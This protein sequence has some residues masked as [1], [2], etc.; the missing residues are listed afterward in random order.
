MA[1]LD[2]AVREGSVL[3]AELL[4]KFGA[5]RAKFIKCD[6]SDEEQLGAAFRQVFDKYRRLD[7]V[8]NNAAMLS[9]DDRAYK[10]IV[11]VNFVSITISKLTR[12][13]KDTN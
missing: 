11:D 7:V 5:L 6:I 2:I 13:F 1:F 8:I 10:K 4:E 9:A 3:E 12:V